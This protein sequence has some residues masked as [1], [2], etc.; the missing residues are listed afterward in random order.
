MFYDPDEAQDK[1]VV[2]GLEPLNDEDIQE[3]QSEFAEM[4]Q[5]AA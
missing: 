1:I 4:L 5:N 2:Y 3:L